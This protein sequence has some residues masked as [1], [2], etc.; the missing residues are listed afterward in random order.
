MAS[1][2]TQLPLVYAIEI[3][4]A[5]HVVDR[6]R[7]REAYSEV[8]RFEIA[9]TV[10]WQDPLDPESVTGGEATL[11][12]Q[13]DDDQR[14]I[15]LV[16]SEARRA[17]APTTATGVRVELVLESRLAWLQHRRDQRVFRDRDVPTIVTEVCAGLGIAVERRLSQGYAVRPYTV[18]HAESDLAFVSRLL[19]DEGIH[20][21]LG[22]DDTLILGD[23]PS[24]YEPAN[25]PLPVR[26]RTGMDRNLDAVYDLGYRGVLGAGKV[27]VRDFDFERPSLDVVGVAK[28]PLG[29]DGGPEWYQY[30][31]ARTT[32]SG[33]QRK[34]QLLAEAFACSRDRL[35]GRCLAGWLRP[36]LSVQL[37]DVPEGIDPSPCAIAVVNH[38]F[39]RTQDGFSVAFE[40][41]SADRTMRPE[42][43]TPVPR[44][45]S[46]ITGFVT[47]PP[48]EDIHTDK[49][50]RVKVHFP[51]DRLQPKDD[52]CSDWIPTLQD[53]TGRSSAMPRIGWEVLVG[54]LEGDP[55]R[56]IILGRVY[57]GL[58]P[59][60]VLL[61]R[62]KTHTTLR[63]LTSPR[64]KTGD[65]GENRITFED[66]SGQQRVY[67]HAER[68]RTVNVARDKSVTTQSTDSRVVHG[69][70]AITVG[71]ERKITVGRDRSMDVAQSQTTTIGASRR[72]DV[73]KNNSET[74]A[75][76]RTVTIGGSYFRRIGT[77]DTVN[78]EKNH[79][80]KVGAVALEASV[81]TNTLSADMISLSLVGG[82]MI[83]VAKDAYSQTAGR[84]R[85]EVV[86]GVLFTKA[87]KIVSTGVGKTRKSVIGGALT[88]KAGEDILLSGQEELSIASG[89]ALFDGTEK[90]LLKVQDTKIVLEKGL[91][92][93]NAKK[94][95]ITT[96][97][98]NTLAAA[99]SK[100][101]E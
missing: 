31:S 75:A 76:N 67:M 100:Q 16:V 80:E 25:A 18:Q 27:T 40:A 98:H 63:S 73:G 82:A 41:L 99:K 59:H 84:A 1:S 83:H 17:A 68:D 55:D 90:A 78:T 26:Q 101:N 9:F 50:G 92:A 13:R 35:V 29:V 10:P 38:D 81:K 69:N 74:V 70:E 8:R 77:I 43:R 6:V 2:Q 72:I 23:S 36:G 47:G 53:N 19:E 62:N 42:P 45:P 5:R 33:A 14:R 86:G 21:L 91:I 49:W 15:S 95:V 66:L 60:F 24:A 7:G 79:T 54:F 64:S 51:W 88:V 39:S 85:A 44:S 32:T 22:D 34:A 89:T 97:D 37:L 3:A 56:P 87:K 46:P 20:Y 58:D 61:P 52:T 11:V 30:P 96:Q 93:F 57:N 12:L 4:G 94:I 65:T 71:A 48:G 28:V